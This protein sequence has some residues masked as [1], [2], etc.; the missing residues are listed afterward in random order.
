M[1]QIPSS[2]PFTITSP[3][4]EHEGMIPAR[5]TCKGKNINPPLVITGVPEGTKSLALIFDDPD[6]PSRTWV[7]WTTW[8]IPAET[9]NIAEGK[10]PEGAA[11]GVTS[12]GT[13][14]YGGPCPP[15]GVHRYYFKFYA[16]STDALNLPLNST[17]EEL[18]TALRPHLIQKTE[19]MG[20]FSAQ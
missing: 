10:V 18:E 5:Y 2:Q 16:L 4:F 19:L 11:E 1:F 8:N 14:G 15:S 6:A 9:V 13:A 17:A 3:A 7:H 12:F 20:R